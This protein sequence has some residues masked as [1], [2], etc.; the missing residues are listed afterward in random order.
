MTDKFIWW[1]VIFTDICGHIILILNIKVAVHI[2]LL[3]SRIYDQDNAGPSSDTAQKCPCPIVESLALTNTV[4][5]INMTEHRII[6]N[7]FTKL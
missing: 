3:N 2:S 4:L 1:E 7:T 5:E 6:Y